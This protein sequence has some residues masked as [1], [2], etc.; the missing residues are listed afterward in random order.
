MTVDQ[1]LYMATRGGGAFF[2]K[3]GAFEPGYELDAIVLDDT[4]LVHPQPLSVRSRLERCLYLADD[5]QLVA[6]YVRGLRL[7]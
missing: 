6:K 1:A 2:G 4:A 5:R 3:V 7:F